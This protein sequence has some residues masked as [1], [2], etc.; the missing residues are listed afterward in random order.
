MNNLESSSPPFRA[1]LGLL[2][3]EIFQ[4]PNVREMHSKSLFYSALSGKHFIELTVEMTKYQ[5]I[6]VTGHWRGYHSQNPDLTKSVC[7][8][9]VQASDSPNEE[10]KLVYSMPPQTPLLDYCSD[11]DIQRSWTNCLP[12]PTPEEKM[13]LESQ[14]VATDVIPINITGTSIVKS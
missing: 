11:M 1:P 13:R 14:S 8:C 4:P 5:T 6:P 9:C 3:R 7:L 2:L 12:L 10:E